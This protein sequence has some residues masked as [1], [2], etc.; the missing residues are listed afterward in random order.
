M[1]C[2]RVQELA[3][4]YATCLVGLF[5]MAFGITLMVDTGLGVSPISSVPYVL[6]QQFSFI[7]LGM[8]TFLWNVVLIL[9]QI[10]I[11]RKEF[12]PLELLQLPL[13]FLFGWFVDIC[14]WLLSGM[15]LSEYWMSL[16]VLLA[17]C[18]VLAL[19]A[20]LTV[21]SQTVMNSGEAFVNAVSRKTGKVFGNIKVV[22]DVSLVAIA[23]ILSLV[24]FGRIE[25]VRE[26][27]V[28]AA[29][30]SGFII[31]ALSRWI[32]PL[33]NRWYHA[34]SISVPLEEQP[35]GQES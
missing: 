7:S 27:T 18:L 8:F 1:F 12:K 34:G 13:S 14:K 15:V 4:R 31:R 9:G 35:V 20:C 3:K 5:V 17:G 33:L 30:V 22:F 28:I 32:G 16:I 23:V 24:F 19:G 2:L 11:L 26:G 29:L 25:G 6:N 10:L 21:L